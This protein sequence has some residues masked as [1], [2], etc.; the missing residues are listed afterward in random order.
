[1]SQNWENLGIMENEGM[2]EFL[3]HP[4]VLVVLTSN[5]H[6]FPVQTLICTL[7]DST[8]SS[9]SLEFNKMK[10]SA[11]PWADQWVGSLTV[12]ERSVLVY[13]LHV[14]RSVHVA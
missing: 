5:D 10:C 7:L 1:M 8:E 6:N 4:C 2:P 12:E 3:H 11:K 9:L 14:T 13:M